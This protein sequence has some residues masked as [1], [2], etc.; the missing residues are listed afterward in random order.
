MKAV[1]TQG[2]GSALAPKAVATQAK[3]IVLATRAVETQ[4]KGL[5]VDLHTVYHH[6]ESAVAVALSPRRRRDRHRVV[7]LFEQPHT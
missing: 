6:G 1:E 3:C 7:V 2:K 5:P 4:G